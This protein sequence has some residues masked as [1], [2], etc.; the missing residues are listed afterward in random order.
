MSQ[1]RCAGDGM[2]EHVNDVRAALRVLERAGIPASCAQSG[3]TWTATAT[4]T[5]G[6]TF[7]VTA[8]TGLQAVAELMAAL[9]FVDLE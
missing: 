9:G 3:E 5:N 6:H 1:M 4:D 8:D 7:K 2:T